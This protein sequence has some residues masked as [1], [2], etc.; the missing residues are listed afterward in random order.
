MKRL[1]LH[2]YILISITAG[3][4][5]SL[6]YAATVPGGGVF[7]YLGNIIYSIGMCL[8]PT[9]IF[10]T[11]DRKGVSFCGKIEPEKLF[12]SIGFALGAWAMGQVFGTAISEILSKAGIAKVTQISPAGDMP[13]VAAGFVAICIASP[14]FEELFFRGVL[15]RKKEGSAAI[16]VTALFFAVAHGSITL[17]VSPFIF[18]VVSGYIMYKYKNI[19]Y[20]IIMHVFANALSWVLTVTKMPVATVMVVNIAVVAVAATAAA[21]AAIFVVKHIGKFWNITKETVKFFFSDI[22][23]II[24]ITDYILKNI[25]FHL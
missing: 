8:V 20:P 22:L 15:M 12:I 24:I 19:L 10:L 6:I 1:N 3:R 25:S 7:S 17:F 14:I 2:L 13:S 9:M 11:W 21:V 23:W 16:L 18:G 4:L 5:F